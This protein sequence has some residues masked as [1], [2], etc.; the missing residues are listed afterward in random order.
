M[1]TNYKI[2]RLYN[3]LNAKSLELADALD[4]NTL[5]NYQK[6]NQLSQLRQI[7]S[8]IRTLQT[9]STYDGTKLLRLPNGSSAPANAAIYGAMMFVQEIEK[10]LKS[11]PNVRPT[12]NASPT[13]QQPKTKNRTNNSGDWVDQL[14]GLGLGLFGLW[15][16]VM[17][18]MSFVNGSTGVID[19]T[20][21]VVLGIIL[22]GVA[23]ACWLYSYAM[24][25]NK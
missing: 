9:S 25:N 17:A 10:E 6:Q 24:F 7:V 19:A 11:I 13:N 23:C 21:G 3:D 1:G 14:I 16:F 4:L 12:Q 2:E 5:S 20:L 18:I 22:L 8:E 15:L